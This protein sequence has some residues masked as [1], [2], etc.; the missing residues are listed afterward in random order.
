[1]TALLHDSTRLPP[2]PAIVPEAIGPALD[3]VIAEHEATVTQLTASRPSRFAEAWLPL[4]RSGT[5]IDALWSAVSHLQAVADTPELRAAHA[6]GQARLV[7]AM[8]AVQQNRDLH[9]LYAAL[10][11]SPDFATLPLADRVAVERA[12]RDFALSGV[13]LEPEARARFAAISVELSDLSNAFASAVLDATDAWT[14]H[15]AD[16]ALLAGLS[17]ADIAMFAAAAQARGLDGWVVTLQQPS[18]TAVLTFAEDRALRERVYTAYGTRASDQ[19]PDAGRFD[20]G[21]RIARILALR[22][23]A[24]GLLGFADPVEW[25]LATKMAPNAG[26]V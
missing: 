7:E 11:A 5:A 10:A 19:G 16:A 14:E 17:D 12:I 4:E 3:A 21:D 13:A 18:V 25:S 24:A 8:M 1:M 20:N 15:V 23:E 9:D 26:E 22:R 6:A 2:F